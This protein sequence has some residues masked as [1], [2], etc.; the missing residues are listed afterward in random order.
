VQD[1][2][3]RLKHDTPGLLSM[4]N[5]GPDTNGSQFFLT[6]VPCPH[7][8]GSVRSLYGV[9]LASE[10]AWRSQASGLRRTLQRT[11]A[12]ASCMASG[13]QSCDPWVV[14]KLPYVIARDVCCMLSACICGVQHVVFGM[15]LDGQKLLN[16]F[17]EEAGSKD[18][19]PRV[20]VEIVGCG[21]VTGR[22]DVLG[23]S[24]DD[25]EDN[26]EDEGLSA[27][28]ARGQTASVS[29]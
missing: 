12:S 2:G 17:E 1:E 8:D 3:F 25:S 13:L 29:A 6:F 19:E 20:P 18:G 24:E 15:L 11:P 28:E 5:A 14:A 9:L 16:K 22:P 27:E 23:D 26:L 7:L 10:I 21:D 4:A